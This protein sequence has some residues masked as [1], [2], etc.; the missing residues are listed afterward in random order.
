MASA[1]NMFQR[2]IDELFKDLLNL[3]GIADTILAV[4]YDD[5]GR[6]H[7]KHCRV[8]LI[9]RNVNPDSKQKQVSFQVFFNPIFWQ[10]HLQTWC[11]I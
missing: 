5:S 6:D 3:L 8:L 10:D 7:D 11:E 2:K 4:G 9:C 1:G